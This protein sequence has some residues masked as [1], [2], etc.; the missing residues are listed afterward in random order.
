MKLLILEEILD[1][2]IGEWTELP[3]TF[4]LSV[5]DK[6]LDK[7]EKRLAKEFEKLG[8]KYVK[9]VKDKTDKAIKKS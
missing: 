6:D 1:P 9:K 4:A 5:E 7:E 2:P 3:M 8:R